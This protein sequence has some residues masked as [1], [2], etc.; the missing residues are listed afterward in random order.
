MGAKTLIFIG[1]FAGS[2]AG[3]YIP[4]LWGE[5]FFSFTSILTSSAGALIGIYLGYKLSNF[6]S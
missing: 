5:D 4:I 2:I 6:L 3:G 1:M